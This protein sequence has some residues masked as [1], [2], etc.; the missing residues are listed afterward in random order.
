MQATVST[1]RS[2]ADRALTDKAGWGRVAL[3][4]VA[5]LTLNFLATFVNVWPTPW[6]QPELRIGP[7]VLALW[8]ALMLLAGIFKPIGRRTVTLFTT[9]FLLMAIGR[10]AD[11]TVPALFGRK[12][13]L[14]WDAYHLPKFLEVASQALSGWQII[15]ILVAAILGFWL[16]VRLIKACVTV[17][18][19]HTAPAALRSPVAWVLTLACVALVGADFARV[20]AASPYVAGPVLPVYSRQADL[21]LAAFLPS[22][23]ANALPP[24]PPLDS[25][26]QA[27]NGAEVK[28]VFVESYGATTYDRDDIAAVIGPARKRLEEAARSQGNHVVSAF[29]KAATFGGASDLS[30]LSF[31]SGIDLTDPFRHDVL[32]TSDRQT[33]LDTFEQAG[34][35][36]IGLYPAMSWAWPEESFYGFDHYHDGPS[37]DYRGPELGLWFLPDQFSMARINELYPPNLDDKPRFIF[38]PTINSHIPYRPTPPYQPDWAR[39]TSETPFSEEAAAAALA[40]EIDWTRLFDGYISTIEYTLEWLAGYLAL[41][42]PRE[43]VLIIVGDHQP[44]GGITGPDP[45]WNVPVHIVTRNPTIAE[46]LRLSGFEDGVDPDPEA[47]GHISDLNQ[48]VL[49]VFDSRGLAWADRTLDSDRLALNAVSSEPQP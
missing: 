36:T 38:Y 49:S 43:S 1:L 27:L 15:G 9:L 37:L 8:V 28:V 3:G 45:S 11:V 14:Y 33:M 34:Y 25:D 6:V 47:I 29:V 13:N 5:L 12:M 26:L 2:V 17:L 42:Q 4:L 24:S 22:R 35:R 21:L 30:H 19:L 20:P 31:L 39:I 23:R 40:D 48:I 44:A 41:P 7:E 10:Y 46:R 32:L 18:A 16:L